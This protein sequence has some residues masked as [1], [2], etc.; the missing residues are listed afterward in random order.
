MSIGFNLTCAVTGK[1][2]GSPLLKSVKPPLIPRIIGQVVGDDASHA[3]AT[4]D[5]PNQLNRAGFFQVRVEENANDDKD[6]GPD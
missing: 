1:H 2:P 6:A 5:P 3:S 4:D